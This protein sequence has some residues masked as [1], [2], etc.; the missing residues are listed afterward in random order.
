[1]AAITSL[2]RARRAVAIGATRVAWRCRTH[3]PR[4]KLTSHA[5]ALTAWPWGREQGGT[6]LG[7][8]GR[9]GGNSGGSWSSRPWEGL[10][11]GLALALGV[12]VVSR[13]RSPAQSCG[14]VGVVS[15]GD[16]GRTVDAREYL[17]EVSGDALPARKARKD[18][19]HG[20]PLSLT[21]DAAVHADDRFLPSL[22]A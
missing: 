20:W 9:A 15:A 2:T 13:D 6:L 18:V 10:A 12:G 1:M 11:A 22:Y 4:E 19:S 14:I 8:E 21:G 16:T 17:L 7:A 5:A 3:G